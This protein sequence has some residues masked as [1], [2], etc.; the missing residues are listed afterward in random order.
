MKNLLAPLV[1]CLSLYTM[2]ASAAFLGLDLG[3]F[4]FELKSRPTVTKPRYFDLLCRAIQMHKQ[5]EIVLEW[6]EWENSNERKTITKQLILEPYLIGKTNDGRPL[7]RGNIVSEKLLKETSVKYGDQSTADQHTEYR[8]SGKFQS[9]N[10]QKEGIST[11]DI[12]QIS[13]FAVLENTYFELPNGIEQIFPKGDIE[14]ICSI[15]P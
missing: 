8:V 13:H 6:Q 14:V 9:K 2:S 11:L 4:E 3:P 10:P 5:I 7:L 15:I 1:T 12:Q